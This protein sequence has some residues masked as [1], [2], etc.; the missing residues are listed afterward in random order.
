[1]ISWCSTVFMAYN[2]NRDYNSFYLTPDKVLER[3]NKKCLHSVFLR[4]KKKLVLLKKKNLYVV[5]V[6]FGFCI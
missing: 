6:W 3:K 2:Y 1:M 4:E 5:C